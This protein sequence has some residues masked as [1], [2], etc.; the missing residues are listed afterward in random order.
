MVDYG[1]G[2]GGV[3]GEEEVY[4]CGGKCLQHKRTDK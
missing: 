2:G 3:L 1:V 4:Q